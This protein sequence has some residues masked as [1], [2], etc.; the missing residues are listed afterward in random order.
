[1]QLLA[2]S[3]WLDMFELDHPNNCDPERHK[4]RDHLVNFASLRHPLW[5]NAD[6]PL[7]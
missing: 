1:M 3:Q 2:S 7:G 4:E 5:K 6:G